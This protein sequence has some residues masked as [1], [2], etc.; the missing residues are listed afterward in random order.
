MDKLTG[1]MFEKAHFQK[2]FGT[3][4]PAC[5][6]FI[7]EPNDVNSKLLKNAM[8]MVPEYALTQLQPYVLIPL[9]IHL[10]TNKLNCTVNVLDV[11]TT[12]LKKTSISLWPTFMRIYKMLVEKL[13]HEKNPDIAVNLSEDIKL[14]IIIALNLLIEKADIVVLNEM[15]NEVDCKHVGYL[16]Y[17][18]TIIIKKEKMNI[19]RVEALKC[20]SMLSSNW[21][22]N[23]ESNIR[24]KIIQRLIK[25]VPGVLSVCSIIVNAT[26]IQHHSITVAAINLWSTIT[27]L[28]ICDEYVIEDCNPYLEKSIC[29][30]NENDDK[31][32]LN[33][34]IQE[35]RTNFNLVATHMNKTREH[36]HW[37]V[38]LQLVSS[39]DVLLSKCTSSMKSSVTSLIE[40]LIVLSDDEQPEVEKLANESVDKLHK[41][42][43]G[44]NKKSLLELLE[45]SFYILLSR[46]PRFIRTSNYIEQKTEL[47]LLSGYI[48]LFGKAHLSQVLNSYAHLDRLITALIQILELEYKTITLLEESSIRDLNSIQTFTADVSKNVP[49]KQLIHFND[50]SALHKIEC[51]CKLIGLYGDSNFI[52]RYLMDLFESRA[53]YRREITLLINMVLSENSGEYHYNLVRDVIDLY[54]ESDIWY[55][56]T[57][58]ENNSTTNIADAQKNVIQI[59]LMTEGLSK[60]VS[61]LPVTQQN[62]CLIHCLYPIL[63]RVGSEHG[64]ISLAGQSAITLLAHSG[65]YRDPIDLVIKNS[66]YLSHHFT[67]KLWSISKHPEVLNALKVVMNLNSGDDLLQSFHTMVTEVLVQSCDV[68]RTENMHSFMKVFH[69]FIMCVR[70]REQKCSPVSD[71]TEK[72]KSSSNCVIENILQYHKMK[73]IDLENDFEDE[74]WENKFS[75]TPC[76]NNENVTEDDED[77]EDNKKPLPPYI[78]MVLSIMKRVLHYLPSKHNSLPLQIL[79]EGLNVISSYEDQLLPMVH[80]IWSPLCTK[81]NSNTDDIVF[82]EAFNVLT[83]MASTAKDFIRSRSLKQVLPTITERLASS[84]KQSRKVAKGSVYFTSHKYKMQ[85]TILSGLADFV[86]NLNFFEKDMHDVSN[87]VAYY[88]DKDQPIELQNKSK[89]FYKK[90]YEKHS[91]FV[92]IYLQSLYVDEYEYKSD[93]ERLPTIK[94]YSSSLFNKCNISKN[95]SELLEPLK[96]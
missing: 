7:T 28:I 84:A 68:H 94:V 81:F 60:L 85:Y 39:C 23:I 11:L 75:Y 29:N 13:T 61:S 34:W 59:C 66:D 40:T 32:K 58:I 53:M 93:N 1:T 91:D 95:V 14:S 16:I 17:I 19:L 18:C 65:G 35:N 88:L 44:Q 90:L 72:S 96:I 5:D 2:A 89:E 48:K 42:F 38:R 70:K 26:D 15:Y 56:P 67:N 4:K 50:T 31:Q 9:E 45:E 27:S 21:N 46:I 73:T 79:N 20:I 83:T 33:D 76:E 87:S 51:I 22:K 54:L 49:W 71:H 36:Q 69:I 8:A 43:D 77:D 62:L 64:P 55:L 37:R 12:L 10:K 24:L 47:S 3:L 25:F 82:R 57:S 30:D 78:E 80:K 52:G 41:I 63:E 86:L 6:A 92:W 74:C